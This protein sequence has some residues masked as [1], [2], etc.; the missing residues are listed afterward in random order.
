VL[1][2]DQRIRWWAG[3]LKRAGLEGGLDDLRARAFLDLVLGKD[4]RPRGPRAAATT[5]TARQGGGTEQQPPGAGPAGGAGG[6]FTGQVTLTVPLGTVAGL[7]DRPG[8]LAGLG[9]VDPW[10]ARDLAAAA[11][12]NPKTTWCVTVTDQ[13]GHAVG[14]GCARPEPKS[15]RRPGFP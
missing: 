5:D 2:C 4:S 9:P 8:E 11:A 14:Y 7:G 10:L 1:A 6:G 12:A 13:H 15:H 3:E